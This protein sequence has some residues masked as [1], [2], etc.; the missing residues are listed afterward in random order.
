MSPEMPF[1]SS[2]KITPSSQTLSKAL[3]ISKNTRLTSIPLGVILCVY[4]QHKNC[5]GDAWLKH[6][7]SICVKIEGN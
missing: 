5:I 7:S 6:S 2:L 1:C 4:D 3:D